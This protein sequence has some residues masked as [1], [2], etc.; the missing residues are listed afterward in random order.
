MG[1]TDSKK[2]L[3]ERV[4][5]G[6]RKLEEDI[7]VQ[8]ER[9]EFF[10]SKSPETM[11]VMIESIDKAFNSC[12]PFLESVLL[13]AYKYNPIKCQNIILSACK[14]VLKAPIIKQ[15]YE[16]FKQY[17]FTSSIWM[18]KTKQNIWMHEELLNIAKLMSQDIINSMDDIY[19]HLQTHKKWQQLIDIKNE[20]IVSRQDDNK[21]GLLQE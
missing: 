6:R 9:C 2:Q 20:T 5:A 8:T 1:N 17:V 7:K 14:K 18:F 21:V 19:Q 15:E 3:G 11:K 13:V 16:W 10:E 4:I 12:S